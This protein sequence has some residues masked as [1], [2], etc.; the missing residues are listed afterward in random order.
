[1]GILCEKWVHSI[2][3]I[4]KSQQEK[5]VKIKTLLSDNQLLSPPS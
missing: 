2:I 1:M 5:T 3:D 4:L